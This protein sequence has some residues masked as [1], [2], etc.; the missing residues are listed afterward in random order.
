M[1]MD[2]RAPL[3]LAGVTD[4]FGFPVQH[5]LDDIITFFGSVNNTLLAED[6]LSIMFKLYTTFVYEETVLL[7]FL[8]DTDLWFQFRLLQNG[9][10][11]IGYE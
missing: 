5:G 6:G 8:I 7:T 10:L 2:K 1:A 9:S 4:L 3:Y 11:S